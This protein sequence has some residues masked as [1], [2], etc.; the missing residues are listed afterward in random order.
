MTFD[1][2]LKEVMKLDICISGGKLVQMEERAHGK[3]QR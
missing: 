1:Q 2:D 3:A